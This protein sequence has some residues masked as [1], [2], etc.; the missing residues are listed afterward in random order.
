[1]ETIIKGPLTSKKDEDGERDKEKKNGKKRNEK[2][3]QWG[4]GEGV[5]VFVI[6]THARTSVSSSGPTRANAL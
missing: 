3:K 5:G 6:R 1:M 2:G 4:G